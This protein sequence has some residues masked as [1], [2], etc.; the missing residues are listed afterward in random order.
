MKLFKKGLLVGACCLFLSCQI[1][2]KPPQFT[3]YESYSGENIVY[4]DGAKRDAITR[5]NPLLKKLKE[6]SNVLVFEYDYSEKIDELSEE[7]IQGIRDYTEQKRVKIFDIITVSYGSVIFRNTV[8]KDNSKMFKDS[9][10]IE[11]VPLLGGSSYAINASRVN[12]QKCMGLLSKIGFKDFRGVSNVLDPT[13][14][15][16]EELCNPKSL[17]KYFGS[18]RSGYI[19]QM[20]KD[21]NSPRPKDLEEFKENYQ[22]ARGKN[23]IILDYLGI[24][25]PH[26]E[27]LSHV[28][29][30]EKVR[31][32]ILNQ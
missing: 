26:Q 5:K 16:Q 17:K 23:F 2:K 29:E 8:L 12:R 1:F 3:Y 4:V 25:D 32:R 10:V 22:R 20:E 30:I 9:N 15:F 18:V 19:I 11:L 6:S 13:G 31:S 21:Q 28:N 14:N 24:T 27:I 7:L